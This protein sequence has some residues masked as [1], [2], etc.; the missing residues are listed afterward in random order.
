ML[1]LQESEKSISIHAGYKELIR[2]PYL[3]K[4]EVTAILKYRELE[5]RINSIEDLKE[6][7]SYPK[8]PKK[9][10]RIWISDDKAT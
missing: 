1:I 9:L 4:Y 8:R 2:I 7:N 5:G 3:E 6:T 10:N